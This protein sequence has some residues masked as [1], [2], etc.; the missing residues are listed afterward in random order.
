MKFNLTAKELLTD[1]VPLIKENLQE[2]KKLPKDDYD[3]GLVFAYYDVLSIIQMEAENFDID[4]Q[5][6]GL[7][8]ELTNDLIYDNQQSGQ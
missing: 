5:E 7:K 3:K 2:A 4:L 6:I 8:Y 1:L